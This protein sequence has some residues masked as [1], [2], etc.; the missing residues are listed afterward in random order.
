M[1]LDGVDR[2]ILTELQR[3]ARLSM[4]ELAG[5]VG[6]ST[7]TA[8]AKVK[9]LEAMGVIRGYRA[10]LDARLL[11]RTGHLVEVETRPALA[12]ALAERLSGID[13]VEEVVET[14]GGRL[15][16]RYLSE[17]HAAM[18]A[19]MEQ[20]GAMEEVG[21]Y[22]VHPIVGERAGQAHAGEVAQRVDIACHFCGGPIHGAGVHKRWAEDGERP[23]WFCCRNCAG[24]FGA[25]L[26]RL[27]R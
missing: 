23:H 5:R 18:Q 10:T 21:T 26:S 1:D 7:P 19:L 16:V 22:R 15:F 8:S 25:K 9:A 3:D 11:G 13:G 4:R 14:A 20:L 24:S 17:G 27:A 2:R 12:R 6:V